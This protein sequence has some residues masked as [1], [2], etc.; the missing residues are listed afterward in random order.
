[1]AN[2]VNQQNS[3]SSL[4][5]FQ[6]VHTINY[7]HTGNYLLVS[8]I[9]EEANSQNITSVTWDGVAMTQLQ[10]VPLTQLTTNQSYLYGIKVDK[11][12]ANLVITLAAWM[13]QN[14]HIEFLSFVNMDGV[15][16]VGYAGGVNGVETVLNTTISQNSAMLV[17][18]FGSTKILGINGTSL[19]STRTWIDNVDALG[20]EGWVTNKLS[21]GSKQI[22]GIDDSINF[23]PS[24]VITAELQLLPNESFSI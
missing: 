16:S 10:W 19:G 20:I 4:P 8:I 18:A 13:D 5:S 7:A 6:T 11:K 1:M 21:A 17:V 12:T 15:G 9:Y 24:D 2:L 14:I 23:F 22:K 3:L